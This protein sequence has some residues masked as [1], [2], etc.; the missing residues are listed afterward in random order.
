MRSGSITG[1]RIAGLSAAVPESVRSPVED[2]AVFGPDTAEKIRRVSGVI[3]RHVTLEGLCTSDLCFVAGESLLDGLKW[4]RSSVDALIF[5][6]QTPDYFLPATGCMLQNRLGLA[7]TCAAFDVNLGCS[8]YVY[9]LWLASALISG[10]GV[11]RILLLVGDTVSRIVS[12]EDRSTAMLFGDAGTA[13]A[14]EAGDADEG[15]IFELGTDGRGR[16]KLI[17]PAG[18]FREPHNEMT[19]LRSKCEGDNLRSREDLYMDGSEVFAF[20]IREVIPLIRSVQSRAGWSTDS[21][22]ALV[23]HQANL[24]MLQHIAKRTGFPWEKVPSTLESFGNTSSASIPLTMI[25]SLGQRLRTD[26][27]K[28]LLAGFGVGWSWGA[29]ALTCDPMAVLGPIL[30]RDRTESDSRPD[31]SEAADVPPFSGKT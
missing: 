10:G 28:L 14:I 12:P 21:V 22:D 1:V 9:G 5:V 2:D 6:T 16:D 29:A 27:L 15:M 20:S 18:A 11:R 13:T 31:D 7:R 30:V 24:F 25:V 8:G 19:G 4:E 3:R 23:L 26:S 17:V